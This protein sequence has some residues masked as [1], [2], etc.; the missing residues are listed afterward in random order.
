M[1]LIMWGHTFPGTMAA[2][3]ADRSCD[4]CSKGRMHWNFAAKSAGEN[5]PLSVGII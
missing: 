5:V 3:S 4:I 2:A 1:M